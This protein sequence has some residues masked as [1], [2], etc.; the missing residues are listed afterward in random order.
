MLK[1]YRNMAYMGIIGAVL[2]AIGDW[3]IYLYPG[4]DL[5]GRI[6]PWTRKI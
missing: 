2:F 5:K 4:L 3:L 6:R 1:K